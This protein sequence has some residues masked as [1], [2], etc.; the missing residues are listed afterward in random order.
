M[1]NEWIYIAALDEIPRQGARVIETGHGDIAVFRTLSDQVFALRDHCP[2]QGGPLSQGIVHGEKVTCPLHNW[3][4][5]LNSGV[6]VAPDEG[7]AQ[8]YAVKVE[9]MQVFVAL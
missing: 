9:H 8:R 2:H 1:N 3:V 7:C 6:A 5:E 4:I